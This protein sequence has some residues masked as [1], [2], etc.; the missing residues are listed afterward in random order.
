MQFNYFSTT[1]HIFG[2]NIAA[3]RQTRGWSRSFL[4]HKAGLSPATVRRIEAI[5]NKDHRDGR[6]SEL[7]SP[8]YETCQR[9]CRALDVD[10]TECSTRL[11]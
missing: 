10:F 5:E 7:Y 4:A 3:L 2:L 1:K 8:S 11:F 6:S 9:I